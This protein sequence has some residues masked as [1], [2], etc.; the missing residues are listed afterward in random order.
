M[1]FSQPLKS[2]MGGKVHLTDICGVVH[3]A[4]AALPAQVVKERLHLLLPVL[5]VASEG[6]HLPSLLLQPLSDLRLLLSWDLLASSLQPIAQL[7]QAS[8]CVPGLQERLRDTGQSAAEESPPGGAAWLQPWGG[9]TYSQ[10]LQEHLHVC[11]ALWV[12]KALVDGQL[13]V[14]EPSLEGLPSIWRRR[15]PSLMMSSTRSSTRRRGELSPL[16]TWTRPLSRSAL[17]RR[18]RSLVWEMASCRRRQSTDRASITWGLATL[19]TSPTSFSAASACSS[20]ASSSSHRFC[21]SKWE[22]TLVKRSPGKMA[23]WL[24]N[25]YLYLDLNGRF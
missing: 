18:I 7:I 5:A 14:L 1:S 13:Q 20:W 17:F 15:G 9:G 22:V 8:V 4:T 21:S 24:R 23:A 25:V 16:R 10:P 2:D 19:E 12:L 3:P 11:P 6:G